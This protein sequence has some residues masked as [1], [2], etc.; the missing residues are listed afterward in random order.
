MRWMVGCVCRRGSCTRR[1]RRCQ[2]GE[3][4]GEKEWEEAEGHGFWE[5]R[6]RRLRDVCASIEEARGG[7]AV[8]SRRK[9]G[10]ERE[11]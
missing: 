3:D 4:G 7:I 2:G 10:K 11:G 9:S 6:G 8:W 5:R 1:V